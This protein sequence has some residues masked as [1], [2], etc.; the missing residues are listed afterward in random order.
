MWSESNIDEPVPNVCI[1]ERQA[2]QLAAHYICLP[3]YRLPWEALRFEGARQEAGAK[4]HRRVQTL[5]PSVSL[6]S[7]FLIIMEDRSAPAAF[8]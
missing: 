6:C 2:G 7:I 8:C 5:G 4:K 3:P 1:N